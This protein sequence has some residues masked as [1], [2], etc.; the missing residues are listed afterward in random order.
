MS[1]TVRHVVNSKLLSIDDDPAAQ[2]FDEYGLI[3]QALTVAAG[4]DL[5]YID[6][7]FVNAFPGDHYRLLAGLLTSLRPRS[8]VDIG[9]H[10]G[11]GTRVMLDYAPKARIDTFDLTP[12]DEFEKT[13]L[14]EADFVEN[15]GQVKQHLVDLSDSDEFVKFSAL[16]QQADFI[17]VDACKDGVFE[18]KFYSLLS[19]LN[20]ENKTRY[21]LLDDIRFTSE[22]LS[23]RR[24]ESPKIDLT[25]FGH[26][27][28]TGLVDISDGFKFLSH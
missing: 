22:L 9:T 21:M 12:W 27:T 1:Y 18:E 16:L 5:S 28:G 6:N 17:M 14:T 25:S 13:F 24:I 8:I 7:P 10:M 2:V 3:C 4:T 19:T 11:T 23:W 15:G 26:F 20:M